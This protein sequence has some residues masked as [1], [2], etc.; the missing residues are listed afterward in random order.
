M[1]SFLTWIFSTVVQILT[2]TLFCVVSGYV[3]SLGKTRS[4]INF[5]YLFFSIMSFV[6]LFVL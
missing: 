1:W 6:V 4:G 3:F 5:D 2:L